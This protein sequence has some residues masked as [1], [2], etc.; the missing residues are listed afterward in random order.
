MLLLNG[1]NPLFDTMLNGT[2]EKNEAQRKFLLNELPKFEFDTY[3]RVVLLLLLFLIS[4]FVVLHDSFYVLNNVN[5]FGTFYLWFRSV[6]KMKNNSQKNI[7]KL[8]S[9]F[10]C[11]LL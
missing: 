1:V 7:S 9:R 6:Y 2:L 11:R 5:T 4:R 3:C 10:F 8:R